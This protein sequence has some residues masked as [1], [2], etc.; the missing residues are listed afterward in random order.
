MAPISV[1]SQRQEG[2]NNYENGNPLAVSSN[3]DVV[4]LDFRNFR[5]TL[6][7]TRGTPERQLIGSPETEVG[8]SIAISPD[9]QKVVSSISEPKGSS[10]K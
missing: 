2:V 4:F 6:W 1:G 3:G 8:H 9:G 10:A 7:H 5:P